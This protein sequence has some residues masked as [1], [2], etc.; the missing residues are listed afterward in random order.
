MRHER[1]LSY[2]AGSIVGAQQLMQSIGTCRCHRFNNLPLIEAHG[3]VLDNLAC[4]ERWFGHSNMPLHTPAVR[5]RVD[6]FSRNVK[7]KL[8]SVRANWR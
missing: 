3:D 4:E 1:Y 7:S 2:P 6:L 5:Y 8:C